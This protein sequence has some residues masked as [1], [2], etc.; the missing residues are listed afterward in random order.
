MIY[1]FITPK[2]CSTLA[3]VWRLGTGLSSNDSYHQTDKYVISIF[4]RSHFLKTW[5]KNTNILN[6]RDVS[7]LLHLQT[8]VNIFGR[9]AARED[10]IVIWIHLK[11]YTGQTIF[12]LS[13][14][15]TFSIIYRHKHA[16]RAMWKYR[17]T[18]RFKIPQNAGL[19]NNLNFSHWSKQEPG[20]IAL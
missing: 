20:Q 10:F 14:Q 18:L 6:Q 16:S 11:F 1:S 8:K 5:R 13:F 4:Y 9:T 12:S 7:M 2:I 17:N 15:P 19:F 3:P